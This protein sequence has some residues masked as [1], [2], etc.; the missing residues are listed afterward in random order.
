M[1]TRKLFI[2]FLFIT[3]Y[4]NAQNEF[5][6]K[7]KTTNSNENVS[8]SPNSGHFTVNWG[9]GTPTTIGGSNHFHQYTNPGEYIV[10]ISGYF[11]NFKFS[12][13]YYFNR[14]QIIDVI[15]WGT[16]QWS[17]MEETFLFCESLTISATDA[18]N[19]S[20][21]TDMSATF[22][23]CKTLNSNINHWDVSNVTD[24]DQMFR[25]AEAFNQP[26]D[27]WDVRNVETTRSMF[28]Q[29]DSFN[30]DLSDWKTES[31]LVTTGMFREA[32]SF[33]QNIGAWILTTV[34]SMT[35][36]FDNSGLSV[37]NYDKILKDWSNQSPVKTNITIHAIGINYCNSE[38]ERNKL[39]ND[40][41]W[42]INDAG[43]D[44]SKIDT[45]ISTNGN[46]NDPTNW[47]SGVVPTTTDNVI[48]PAGTTLQ[49]SAAVSE[50]NS[51]ENS[52]TIVISPTFSLKS[53]SNMV[54]T[55]TIVMDSGTDDSSVLF[56]EGTATGQ[57][58]Y[59]RGGLK[60][61]QWSLVTPPVSGQKI[62]E[63]ATDANNDIRQNTSASPIRYAIGYYNDASSD[64]NKWNYYNVNVDEN[65]TFTAGQSYAI[66][67]NT[68]GSVS[69]TGTLTTNNLTRT[70]QPGE[71]NAI[72]NPFTTYYPANKNSS[73]SFLDDNY[74]K[75]DDNYK[76]LYVWDNIQN[77]YVLV[78]ELD[79][80]NRSF[81]PGQGFFIK[82]K[83]AENEIKFQQDKRTIKPITGN[84][85]FNKTKDIFV[86]IEANNGTHKVTTDLRFFD[87][88]TNSF[89]VGLDIGNFNSSTFDL[90][91]YLVNDSNSKNYTI[92]SL[93]NNSINQV[94]VPIGISIANDAEVSFSLKHLNLPETAKLIL[95][96]KL[97]NSFIDLTDENSSHKISL[98]ATE[99]TKD[100]FYLHIS[101][102][103]LSINN[104]IEN[105]IKL[106]TKNKTLYVRDILD[107]SSLHIYNLIGQKVLTTTLSKGN[108]VLSLPFKEGVYIIKLKTDNQEV[109]KKVIL[110][111]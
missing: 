31:L 78:S 84:N 35:Q 9:D 66:S 36:M 109:V 87:N 15:Q 68:D 81:A 1:K 100:R 12:N 53:K 42:T 37:I 2:L 57:V 4:C 85:A 45:P 49:V 17:S 76:G 65:L 75:L 32:K 61:N 47:A 105:T 30:Q 64:N 26:L 34:Q 59:T 71:W 99:Q 72:G 74:D 67:R 18:P 77:K 23:R 11:S 10:K 43:K 13:G 62:K 111:Q 33:N 25:D 24:M 16:N 101:S 22:S 7:L 69:F 108:S 107:E 19:L 39:I 86:K 88:A 73:S 90:F 91:T 83:S 51:L 48:I 8:L 106:Y 92:Q 98:T 80:Q 3:L 5:I 95:E 56:I 94:I 41:G 46:W 97:Y 54:N 40:Y 50:I 27:K 14:N 20:N 89:D 28:Y 44:C 38:T 63:F 70:L 58:K 21:V 104:T 79:L 102:Q 29:A 82:L 110:K 6:I 55:G 93:A 103:A 52:G 96:D 60:A